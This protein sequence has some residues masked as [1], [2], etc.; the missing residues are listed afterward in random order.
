MKDQE[1]G[2]G[3]SNDA[4]AKMIASARFSSYISRNSAFV[5]PGLG[6]S[7]SMIACAR[8][9]VSSENDPAATKSRTSRNSFP[10]AVSAMAS[11]P[12]PS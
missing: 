12:Q 10:S 6:S 7:V 5:H 1:F 4:R 9:M 11:S 3:V 8:R 2:V